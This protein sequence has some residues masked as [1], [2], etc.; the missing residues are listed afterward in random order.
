V[1]EPDLSSTPP[2]TPHRSGAVARHLRR[3]L[4]AG[5]LVWIPLAVTLLVLRFLIGLLDNSLLLIPPALRPEG[6]LWG[7]AL[8]LVLVLGTGALTANYLGAQL[9]RFG[10]D[11]VGRIPLI[12]SIY[13]GMKK[14]A[15]TVFSDN[16]VSFRQP[17]LIEY[18]RKGI[19]SIAFITGEPL[20]EVQA[21]TEA[22]V[23]TVFVPTT[24][25]PTSGFIVFVPKDEVIA[26]RMS[27]EDAMRLII[28]LGVVGPEERG[29][30]LRN[31]ARAAG[32]GR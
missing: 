3:W 7:V 17:V 28:S 10:E 14:L 16:S 31:V 1:S 30:E 5:L 12:R 9:I 18:P 15:E 19:W 26:L 24:P 29:Q 21:K 6:I 20:G 27:V 13:G 25:N 23:V 2:S 22:T 32:A 11:V 4:V 8:S